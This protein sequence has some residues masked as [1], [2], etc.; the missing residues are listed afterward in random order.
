MQKIFYGTGSLQVSIYFGGELDVKWGLKYTPLFIDPVG[1]LGAAQ[2]T[3][4]AV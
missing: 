2:N 1:F 4:Q 3:S